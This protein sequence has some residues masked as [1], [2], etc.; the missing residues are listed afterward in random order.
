MPDTPYEGNGLKPILVTPKQLLVIVLK[1]V[2][3]DR[4]TDEEVERICSAYFKALED[5]WGE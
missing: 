4:T 2:F 3:K 1:V 5:M